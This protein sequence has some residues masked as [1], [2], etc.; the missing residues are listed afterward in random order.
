[1]SQ[2]VVTVCLLETNITSGSNDD[3]GQEEEE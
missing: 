1:M 2:Q 3:D